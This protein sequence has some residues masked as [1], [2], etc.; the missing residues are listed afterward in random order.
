MELI[1]DGHALLGGASLASLGCD[2]VMVHDP[3]KNVVYISG[4]LKDFKLADAKIPN[5]K[6]QMM[7]ILT[8]VRSNPD[9]QFILMMDANTQLELLADGNL[10]IFSKDPPTPKKP[11][12]DTE[13]LTDIPPVRGMISSVSTSNKMR[14][15]HT[16]Q[17]DKSFKKINA[18]IDHVLSFN[19]P[20]ITATATL[21]HVLNSAGE[22]VEKD[23]AT[24]TTGPNSIPDH[25]LVVSTFSDGSKFGTLNIKGGNDEDKAWAEFV[26][27]KYASFF[28][29]DG[30]VHAKL[31][32]LRAAVGIAEADLGGYSSPRCGVFDINL[33]NE[34]VPMI[35]I[36]G[37][38][39]KGETSSGAM[40]VVE[41]HGGVYELTSAPVP[42]L[43]HFLRALV[44]DLN[45]KDKKTGE[46][47][48][49]KF[50][51]E[52]GYKLLNYWY[53][54]Q[55]DTT[56]LGGQSLKSVYDEW[57]R[58]SNTKVPIAEIVRKAKTA[59]PDLR[60]L[61]IQEMPTDEGLKTTIIEAITSP[62][63]GLNCRVFCPPAVD[64][65]S[66]RGAIIVFNPMAGGYRRRSNRQSRK[67][68]QTRRNRQSRRSK[69]TRRNRQ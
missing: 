50:L 53:H 9:K 68:K 6:G 24:A 2:T 58:D 29:K 49:R 10:R 1:A 34:S 54:V 57:F 4:H 35:T 11:V 55:N 52:K 60:V 48:C 8:I 51:I 41:N 5:F 36:E 7:G 40:F 14:G 44:K 27:A 66:T 18:V 47:A 37:E 65:C 30:P 20:D 28:R 33:Q 59:H 56:D 46:L 25:A 38:T 42:G 63:L 22:L 13:T 39:V 69:Q 61:A 12:P 45:E 64:G 23:D 3:A 62:I 32:E 31:A 43:V 16:A 21:A 19:K 26:P 17:L 15:V 67:T